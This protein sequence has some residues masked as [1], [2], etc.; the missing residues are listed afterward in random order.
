MKNA[1]RIRNNVPADAPVIVDEDTITEILEPTREADEN[2]TLYGV[3][4]II[5]EKIT[6]GGVVV[7]ING[8]K[9]RKMRGIKSFK[10][11]LD[12]NQKLYQEALSYIPVEAIAV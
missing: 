1:L 7:G 10:K 8:K 6:K 9:A 11:D 12:M 5:Q 4:N 3:F 2:Q